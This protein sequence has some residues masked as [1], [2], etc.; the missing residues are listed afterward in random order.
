M[1]IQCEHCG[2]TLQVRGYE[3]ELGNP[4]SRQWTMACPV[5]GEVH[6]YDSAWVRIAPVADTAPTPSAEKAEFGLNAPAM[7]G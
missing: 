3:Q 1:S 6:L 2:G 4:K 5:C 7:A